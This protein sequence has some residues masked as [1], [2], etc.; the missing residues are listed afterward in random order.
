MWG[1]LA[2]TLSHSPWDASG[3]DENGNPEESVTVT[4]D[5]GNS[6]DVNVK[7]N[8]LISQLHDGE[9]IHFSNVYWE[10]G[11]FLTTS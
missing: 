8:P 3:A 11:T 9:H 1:G 10:I 4:D 5:A 2:G 7:G 6:C